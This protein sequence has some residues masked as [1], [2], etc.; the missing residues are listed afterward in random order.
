MR[1]L[2]TFYDAFWKTTAGRWIWPKTGASLWIVLAERQPRV[3]L[4]DLMMP[5]MD[6]FEFVSQL[7]QKEEY[8]RIPIVVVTAQRPLGRRSPPLKRPS[9]PGAPKGGLQPWKNCWRKSAVRW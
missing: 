7:K 5:E 8:R 4:L 2:A 1:N 6:G 3:I 9:E